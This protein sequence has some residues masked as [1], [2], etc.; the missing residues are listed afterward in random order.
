MRKNCEGTE[1]YCVWLR[2]TVKYES[3]E[4]YTIVGNRE[5]GELHD[6]GEQRDGVENWEI[7]W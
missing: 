1:R 2:D 7:L 5:C 6:C 4:N 3:V